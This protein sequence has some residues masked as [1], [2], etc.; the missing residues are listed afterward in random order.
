MVV[1]VS[2]VKG[3]G[4]LRPPSLH[5]AFVVAGEWLSLGALGNHWVGDS[6]STGA[7]TCD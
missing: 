6:T 3:S 1:W 4:Q 2:D 7:S 5:S